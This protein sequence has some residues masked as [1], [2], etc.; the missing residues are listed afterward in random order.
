MQRYLRFPYKA[1]L[2][3]F[4]CCL[5][6]SSKENSVLRASLN[7][8][9][10]YAIPN[11]VVADQFIPDPSKVDPNYSSNHFTVFTL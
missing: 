6:R 4:S 9:I 10:V 11:A 5:M 1:F 7:P 3:H 8:E 2:L